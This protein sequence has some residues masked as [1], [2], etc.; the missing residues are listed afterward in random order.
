MK[1]LLL[2]L[3]PFSL[4]GQFANPLS[5]PETIE[6][7]NFNLTIDESTYRFFDTGQATNTIGFNGD[8]LGPTLIFNQGDAINISVNNQLNEPTTVHWHGMH[9]SPE[10]D[11]GPH[12]V[13]DAGAV[14]T[15][16]FTVLDRATTFW[17]HPHL[18][19]KTNEHVTKGAAGMIIIRSDAEA[20]LS[21]PRTYGEDDFPLIVQA[22]SFTGL[23]QLN[24]RGEDTHFMV[25]GTLSPYLDAPSQMVR[26]RVLNG[27]NERVLN[28][29]FDDDRTFYQIGSDGGLLNAPLSMNRV[30]LASGERA[31]LVV[32]FSGDNIGDVIRMVTYS[33]EFGP[34]IPGGPGG[35]A[36]GFDGQD[37]EFME[38]R[39]VAATTNPVTSIS[40]QLATH[41]PWDESEADNERT[42]TMDGGGPMNPFSLDNALFDIDFV[43]ETVMLDDIE[44]WSIT[45]NTNTAH[46]FHIHDIQFYILDK[47]GQAPPPN[48]QGLK[49]VVLVEGNQTVRFITKFDDFADAEVPYMYHCHILPHEDGGMMGQFIV[50]EPEVALSIAETRNQFRIYPNPVTDKIIRVLLPDNVDP[51]SSWLAAR[52]RCS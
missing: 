13:I 19:E 48:E 9:V 11:G 24:E 47:N 49:D 27:S 39:V 17:Y 26:L 33:S 40:T 35:A 3:I 21:L 16:D 32:D 45:N 22:K 29:G 46:P 10:D 14:W 52:F 31:E 37:V 41:T 8:F 20:T 30:R 12:T 51:T 2:L 4:F 15:P 6:G 43:N 28:V 1:K 50:I 5:I 23:N 36:Q 42:I 44:I 38:F 7:T 34:G 18:H 25:N